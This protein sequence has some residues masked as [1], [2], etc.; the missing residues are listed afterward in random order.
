[1]RLKRPPTKRHPSQCVFSGQR[2]KPAL[3]CGELPL[4]EFGELLFAHFHTPYFMV[5]KWKTPAQVI[6]LFAHSVLNLAPAWNVLSKKTETP[7]EC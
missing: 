2:K 1:M 3:F 5:N 7:R 6:L 4:E